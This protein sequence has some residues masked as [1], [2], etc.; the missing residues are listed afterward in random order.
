MTHLAW[1]NRERSQWILSVVID[2]LFRSVP[3]VDGMLRLEGIIGLRDSLVAW[4]V[5]L[6]LNYENNGLLSRLW[7]LHGRVGLPPGNFTEQEV[8]NMLTRD[9]ANLVMKLVHSNALVAGFL[10]ARGESGPG[11]KIR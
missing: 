4:R 11:S 1:E 9:G 7:Q 6:A 5:R 3:M 2:T 10:H 8:S